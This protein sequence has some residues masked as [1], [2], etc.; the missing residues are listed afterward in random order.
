MRLVE[1]QGELQ[2]TANMRLSLKK[3]FA[4]VFLLLLRRWMK[5]PSLR[6]R[7]QNYQLARRVPIYF[8]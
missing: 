5:R 2:V 1:F 3:S 6:T 8:S 7:L 4:K